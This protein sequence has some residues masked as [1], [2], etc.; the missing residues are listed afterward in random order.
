MA[1]ARIDKYVNTAYAEVTETGTNT[2]TFKQIDTGVSIFEKTAWIIHR[3]YWYF[4]RTQIAKLVA[5]SDSIAVAVTLSNKM[6]D[7][8]LDDISVV[9]MLELLLFIKGTPASANVYQVPWVRD[10]TNLP[11]GG[12]IVPPRPIYVAVRGYGLSNAVTVAAR[13][14]FTH[15]ELAPDEYWELVEATRIIQ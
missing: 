8:E 6:T 13:V 10:F 3:I 5:S 12:L 1:K 4:N 15:K 11:G 2:L 9:D 7:L 14:L